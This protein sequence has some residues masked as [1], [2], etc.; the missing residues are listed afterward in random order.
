MSALYTKRALNRNQRNQTFIEAVKWLNVLIS[1]LSSSIGSHSE[2]LLWARDLLLWVV[3]QRKL[4]LL[5]VYEAGTFLSHE[6]LF[7]I[8][9]MIIMWAWFMLCDQTRSFCAGVC[10]TVCG[11]RFGKAA[12]CCCTTLACMQVNV[13]VSFWG[14]Y[15]LVSSYQV[16]WLLNNRT[17]QNNVWVGLYVCFGYMVS[18]ETGA[19]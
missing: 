19:C 11:V 8:N 1:P 10:V 2:R 13:L 15:N 4:W 7:F 18:Y 17:S 5:R 6:W 14:E 12:N 16:A 3:L 9:A